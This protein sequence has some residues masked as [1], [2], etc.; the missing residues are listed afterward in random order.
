MSQTTYTDEFCIDTQTTDIPYVSRDLLLASQIT[1][2]CVFNEAKSQDQG[3]KI[4]CWSG[5][6][7]QCLQ[8][9]QVRHTCD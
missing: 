3:H 4:V 2:Q 7:H 1:Y 9:Y 6:T 5:R 8:K